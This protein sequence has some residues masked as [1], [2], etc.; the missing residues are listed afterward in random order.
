[1]FFM[2]RAAE[3][4]GGGGG[5]TKASAGLVS[6]EKERERVCLSEHDARRK[7]QEQPRR[8]NPSVDAR[9]EGEQKRKRQGIRDAM[10]RGGTSSVARWTLGRGLVDK[11]TQSWKEGKHVAR[12]RYHRISKRGGGTAMKRREIPSAGPK[13]GEIGAST[14]GRQR[15]RNAVHFCGRAPIQKVGRATDGKK[16][17][18]GARSSGKRGGSGLGGEPF[19]GSEKKEL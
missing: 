10:K 7:L 13:G 11:T 14:F 19:G 6:R 12:R 15:K 17:S 18:L 9:I 5:K 3:K 1:L 8:N 2:C 4:G 16:T